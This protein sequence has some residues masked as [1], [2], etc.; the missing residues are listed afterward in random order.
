MSVKRSVDQGEEKLDTV[1]GALDRL[2]A[3][4]HVTTRGKSLCR[5]CSLASVHVTTR[6]KSPP[7]VTASPA[8]GAGLWRAGAAQPQS[9]LLLFAGVRA[10]R[11][12]RMACAQVAPPLDAPTR[13]PPLYAPTRVV[14]AAPLA[15]C[16]T[17]T[18]P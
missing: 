5:M 6:G 14:C 9:G 12:R 10:R 8:P 3:S 18:E 11:M 16:A 17:R 4:V 1:Q 15:Q 2:Q 13:A 7:E